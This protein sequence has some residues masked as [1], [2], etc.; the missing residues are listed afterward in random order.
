MFLIKTMHNKKRRR[1]FFNISARFYSVFRVVAKVDMPHI[2]WLDNISRCRRSTHIELRISATYR[3]DGGTCAGINISKIR[4]CGFISTRRRPAQALNHSLKPCHKCGRWRGSVREGEGD[5]ELF[6]FDR[7]NLLEGQKLN[8]ID[9]RVRLFYAFQCENILLGAVQRGN[10][11][12]AQCG[13]Y[14]F[15]I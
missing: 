13:F 14:S 12:L 11:D 10:Y 4:L 9:T 2:V 1:N 6:V 5:A 15:F 3:I 8:G 7:A